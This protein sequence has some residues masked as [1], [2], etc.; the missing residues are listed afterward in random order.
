L[1]NTFEPAQ[2]KLLTPYGYEKPTKIYRFENKKCLEV[3]TE[4]GYPVIA[5]HNHPFLVLNTTTF[6]ME[7]KRAD[8]LEKGDLIAINK[9]IPNVEGVTSLEKYKFLID[10]IA[11]KYPDTSSLPDTMTKELARVLGYL[12]AEGDLVSNTSVRFSNSSK[13]I[14]EDYI[15][16]LLTCFPN[17]KPTIRESENKTGYGNIDNK[18]LMYIVQFNSVRIRRFLYCLGMEYVKATEKTIPETILSAPLDIAADF[19]RAF[20]E[21]DGCYSKHERED[22]SELQ[23]CIFSSYSKNLLVDIQMLLLRFGI[24]STLQWNDNNRCVRISGKSL[25][26]YVKKVGFLFKGTEYN[27]DKVVFTPLRES[28]PELYYAL[29]N[30]VRPL[31]GVNAKGWKNNKR[32]KIYWNH[33]AKG[34][35]NIRWEHIDKWWDDSQDTIKE[36]DPIIHAR[37]QSFVDSKFL[38]KPVKE[39][40]DVGY[41]NVIDPSF[42]SHGRVLDHAFQT[43][44][45]ITHNSGQTV[46]LEHDQSSGLADVAGRWQEFLS[47]TLPAA[48]MALVRRNAPVGT[49]AGRQYRMTDVNLFTF[50]TSSVQGGTNQILSQMTTLG[51]LF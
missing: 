39:I 30:N 23:V 44:G 47:T 43:G 7:W 12:I 15:H 14:I 19:L 21:G 2:I 42:E 25:S 33:N 6:E 26:E 16:C 37:L 20:V 36:L 10:E 48:K 41:R 31:L 35:V 46:T 34:C 18:K 24:I 45:I 38:W 27:S 40:I 8:A 9:N 51:L 22:N 49:V 32:Y 4:L 5:T 13:E 50:K 17:I 29:K 3:S 1:T 28:M 11:L